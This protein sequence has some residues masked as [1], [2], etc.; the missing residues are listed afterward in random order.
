[1][2]SIL[3]RFGANAPALPAGLLPAPAPLPSLIAAFS[4]RAALFGAVASTGALAGSAVRAMPVMRNPMAADDA[5]LI[6]LADTMDQAARAGD[7]AMAG[8]PDGTWGEDVPA[9]TAACDRYSRAIVTLCATPA[10]SLA[11]LEAKARAMRGPWAADCTESQADIG[12]SIAADL[13]RL[14]RV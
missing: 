7:A 5:G 11:G 1:M 12:R 14:E 9:W 6:A 10:G 2:L 3:A 8:Q 13:L 4:R